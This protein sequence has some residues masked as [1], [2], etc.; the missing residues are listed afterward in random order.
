M[1]VLAQYVGVDAQTLVIILVH[2][3]SHRFRKEQ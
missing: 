3:T 1:Q 2:F